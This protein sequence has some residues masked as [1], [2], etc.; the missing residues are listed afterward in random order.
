MGSGPSSLPVT[1][2]ATFGRKAFVVLATAA[3]LCL[4]LLTIAVA[5]SPKPL[6]EHDVLDLLSS[7]VAPARVGE[8][9]HQFGISFEVTPEA[10]EKLRNAG[11]TDSLI[12]TLRDLEPKSSAKEA[13]AAPAPQAAPEPPSLVIQTSPGD[14]DVYLDDEPMGTTSPE[15]RLK[16]V[17][18][19]PGEHVVRVGLAGFRDQEKKVQLEAGKTEN[20]NVQLVA[21]TTPPTKLMGA[22]AS[23]PPVA[24]ND[25]QSGPLDGT[26]SGRIENLTAH[27]SAKATA[28]FRESNGVLDG[29]LQVMRPLF[30]SGRISGSEMGG[31]ANFQVASPLFGI[32][33][34]G[35]VKGEEFSGTYAT[36]AG[37]QGQFVFHH[38][39]A[40]G[41][42]TQAQFANCP[43]ETREDVLNYAATVASR[44]VSSFYVA[45][46]HGEM[47]TY[48]VGI[49]TIGNGA[50][51]YQSTTGIHSFAL[52]LN[53]IK[54]VRRNTVYL[55][56]IG[57]FH[58]TPKNGRPMNFVVINNMGQYLPPNALILAANRAMGI[59]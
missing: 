10:E 18:L 14:A 24:S 32:H 25:A 57:A 33:G 3:T 4:F 37:Q 2:G 28:T 53:D 7:S 56:A 34:S 43:T 22:A 8:L 58:I 55:S 30:G 35:N 36:D 48:C 23:N 20:L 52:P 42:P 39:V 47:R 50:I 59:Y 9:A 54:E 49:M 11:A 41:R 38:D 46:D 19:A 6:S 12:K 13:T 40:M 44:A 26:Y 17:K 1:S 15:G 29:C 16:L 5:Q 51:R 21:S 27:A 45:H 31:Q